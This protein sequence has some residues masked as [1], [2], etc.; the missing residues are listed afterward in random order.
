[1]HVFLNALGATCSSGVTYLRNVIPR[2]STRTGIRTTLAVSPEFREEFRRHANVTV[3]NKNFG[4]S[5]A[6]RFWQ[7]QT[8]LPHLV[9]ESGADVLISAGNF[10]M[11]HSPVPQILLSGNAIYT[12][13][14]FFRDLRT[15]GAYGLWLDTHARG[16]FARRS[17]AWADCTVAPSQWFAREIQ[18]WAGRDAVDIYHGFDPSQFFADKTPLPEEIQRKLTVGADTLRLLFVTHYNYYRNFETLL[19]ALPILRERL[20]A[21]RK[22]RLFLT[23]ELRSGCN[24]GSYRPES[25]AAVVND[26]G[27]REE[28]VELGSI[29]YRSLHHVYKACDVY[30]TPAYAETF[31]HPLVEAMASRLPIVA[32]DL[33]VH[34][35]ICGRAALYFERFDPADLAEQV[36]KLARSSE[37]QA[38]LAVRGLARSRDFS[39][40]KHVNEVL[41]L[42]ETLLA[43]KVPPMFAA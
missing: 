1:M 13:K 25:A 4:R 31:G 30:V 39:W 7:E 10:A 27:I 8:I 12:S 38:E 9:R 18:R 40:A 41:A 17:V 22:L 14:D 23:C 5:P 33:P 2:L 37:S 3:L 28:V 11:H 20:G 6:T 26:L 21:G 29:P 32:S 43:D 15:R 42:A 35:E 19:R 16:F 36:L 24:P 34:R